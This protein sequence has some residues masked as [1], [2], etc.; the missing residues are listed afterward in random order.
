MK[1]TIRDLWYGNLTP[2]ENCEKGKKDLKELVE[3]IAM[4]EEKLNSGLGKG[5]KVLFEKY[6]DCVE[7]YNSKIQE[8]AFFEGLTLGIKIMTS[9]LSDNQ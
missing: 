6:R 5:E 2:F 4:N 1:E 3:L 9:A 7:E 8:N